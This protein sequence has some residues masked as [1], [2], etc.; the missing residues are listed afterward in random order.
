MVKIFSPGRILVLAVIGE[1]VIL[2]ASIGVASVY[3]TVGP[4]LEMAG[5]AG[6]SL[7]L[8]IS[9]LLIGLLTPVAAA[10]YIHRRFP[11][12][13]SLGSMVGYGTIVVIGTAIGLLPLIMA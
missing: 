5:P 8:L 6:F 10:V 12:F 1:Y 2:S 7:P 4:T 11:E 3:S 13:W 9:G